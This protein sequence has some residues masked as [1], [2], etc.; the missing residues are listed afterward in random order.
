[1]TFNMNFNVE[2]YSGKNNFELWKVNMK[3]LLVQQGLKDALL[4]K[5]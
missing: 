2:K 5:R 3:G 4:G 1:M